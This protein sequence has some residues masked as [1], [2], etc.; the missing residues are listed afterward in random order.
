VSLGAGAKN[1]GN[2]KLM[3]AYRCDCGKGLSLALLEVAK[4][5]DLSGLA[6]SSFTTGGCSRL[7][8]AS[9]SILISSLTST[10]TSFVGASTTMAALADLR[11]I[12]FLC[13]WYQ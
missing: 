2:L 9:F 8:V 13:A 3:G 1:P 7:T 11:F 5:L 4:Y 10:F 12:S 6:S